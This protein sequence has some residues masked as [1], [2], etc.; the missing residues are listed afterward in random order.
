MMSPTDQ[1]CHESSTDGVIQARNRHREWRNPASCG[2]LGVPAREPTSSSRISW[3][4]ITPT[5][6]MSAGADDIEGSSVVL[7]SCL[8]KDRQWWRDR[9]LLRL[10]RPTRTIN[11]ILASRV[12]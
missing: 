8:Q 5:A 7:L 4:I 1:S 11:R 2:K 6:R 10:E 12:P 9:T 3:A